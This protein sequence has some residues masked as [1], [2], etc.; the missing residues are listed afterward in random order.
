MKKNARRTKIFLIGYRATGKSTLAARLAERWK[1]KWIDLDAM[2]EEFACA[3]ITDIFARHGESYFRD[4][5]ARVVKDVSMSSEPMVVATGGG[6]PLLES[7]RRVMKEHGVVV[8]LTASVDTI[9]R[10][11]L[12]DETTGS[13]RPA[14]TDSESPIEEIERVLSV[15]ELIY[16]EVADLV[17]DTDKKT[18]DEIVV[19]IADSAPEFFF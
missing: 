6:A 15:R 11:M 12:G 19:E 13:R 9:A 16:R 10:R 4:L 5:E 18:V 3:S 1:I 2:I 17:V 8:W 7:S 14:L